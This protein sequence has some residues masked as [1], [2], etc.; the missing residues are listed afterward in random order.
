MEARLGYAILSA[1]AAQRHDGHLAPAWGRYGGHIV[2]DVL[3]NRS[4]SASE[5]RIA[6]TAKRIAVS[7]AGRLA[8][9][10][11][12]DSG[13][14]CGHTSRG[15]NTVASAERDVLGRC[16]SCVSGPHRSLF[17]TSLGERM[18]ASNVK[19]GD[20]PKR[21]SQRDGWVLVITATLLLTAAASGWA[22]PVTYPV[23]PGV[24]ASFNP[25]QMTMSL[26]YAELCPTPRSTISLLARCSARRARSSLH[27]CSS[28]LRSAF[29]ACRKPLI[30]WG[31]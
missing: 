24:S 28:A 22:P 10:V 15:H 17:P 16:A 23:A 14:I 4:L 1:V 5:T 8:G 19:A 7:M 12:N 2:S 3:D 20:A 6:T 13:Q 30:I 26:S 9:N 18:N 21:H 31:A 25:A 27:Y 11:W 29:P